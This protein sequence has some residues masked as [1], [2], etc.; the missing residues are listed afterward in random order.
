[1]SPQSQ[2]NYLPRNTAS[3]A[4]IQ[5]SHIR[6]Y[7][8]R[9]SKR[10]VSGA[11]GVMHM[12][13]LISPGGARSVSLAHHPGSIHCSLGLS[14]TL[15]PQNAANVNAIILDARVIETWL[16]TR[17]STGNSRPPPAPTITDPKTYSLIPLTWFFLNAHIDMPLSRAMRADSTLTM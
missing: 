1:M 10:L 14:S 17:P 3:A 6:V 16:Q 5:Y 8:G 15:L 12:T 9:P 13:L 4:D 7:Y 2:R 11:T